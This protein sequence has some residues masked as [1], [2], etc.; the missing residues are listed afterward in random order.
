LL[1]HVFRCTTKFAAVKA[2]DAVEGARSMEIP[3]VSESESD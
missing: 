1:M 2:V 3:V